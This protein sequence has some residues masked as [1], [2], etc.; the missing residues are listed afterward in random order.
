MKSTSYEIIFTDTKGQRASYGQRLTLSEIKVLKA[1]L[2]RDKPNNTYTIV[3]IT[4]EELKD[5]VRKPVVFED[6][7]RTR[8]YKF[9][10]VDNYFFKI[11]DMVFEVEEDE[12]DGYRSSMRDVKLVLD[13]ETIKGLIFFKKPLDIVTIDNDPNAGSD[14]SGSQLKSTKDGHGWLLFGTSNTDDYYP[15]FTFTYEPRKS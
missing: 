12:S 14:F 10:G 4:R 1:Q 7:D 2:L 6:L 5:N 13:P 11:D 3:K 15:Y 9:Y 8:E